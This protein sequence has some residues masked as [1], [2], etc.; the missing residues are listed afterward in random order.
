VLGGPEAWRTFEYLGDVAAGGCVA[1]R[2][3]A[4]SWEP[5]LWKLEVAGNRVWAVPGSAAHQRQ[6]IWWQV[7]DPEEAT[8]LSEARRKTSSHFLRYDPASGYVVVPGPRNP[9]SGCVA[10]PGPMVDPRLV[11]LVGKPFGRVVGEIDGLRR[12]GPISRGAEEDKDAILPNQEKEPEEQ[13]SKG[14]P[15]QGGRVGEVHG[16][17]PKMKARVTMLCE[18]HV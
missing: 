2:D 15:G 13:V 12:I 10:G 3:N 5:T 4:S 8:R 6:Q 9:A 14:G 16:M 1:R 7:R 18:G 11:R 17:K